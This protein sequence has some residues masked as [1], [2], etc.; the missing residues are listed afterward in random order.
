MHACLVYRLCQDVVTTS[1][2]GF[3]GFEEAVASEV[4]DFVAWCFGLSYEDVLQCFDMSGKS[5]GQ[6]GGVVVSA[7]VGGSRKQW[8]EWVL[9]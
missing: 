5:R 2:S 4:I 8:L 1:R 6:T 7:S 3:G 9:T